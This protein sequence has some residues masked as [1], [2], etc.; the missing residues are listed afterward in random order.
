MYF[1]LIA[2]LTITHVS[3]VNRLL[4]SA[5]G[6]TT[7]RKNR[8]CWALL[9]KLEGCTEYTC[10]GKRVISDK[11]QP[12][13]LPKGCTYDWQRLVPGECLVIDFEAKGTAPEPVSFQIAD[14]TPL[15]RAFL[16][17]EHSLNRKE[18]STQLECKHLLY[19]MLLHLIKPSE[20][21]YLP[22]EKMHLL[23]PAIEHIEKHY[24]DPSLTNEQ[25]A[26][27][28]G[29]STVYFRK[30]FAS[31]YGIPPIKYLQNFRI[32]KAKSILMSDYDSI[33]QV[34]ESVGYS[35]IYHFSKMFKQHSGISPS[36]YAAQKK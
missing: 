22:K 28:C 23:Q 14:P 10:N 6:V 27:L 11:F 31:V 20:K 15:L 30:M 33:G 3:R 13:L 34:A 21:E 2:N 4:S 5:S 7:H 12:I 35:S 19:G 32:E 24:H 17:I 8:E 36:K 18:V 26:L 29:V 16:R 1:D 25:L 9:L